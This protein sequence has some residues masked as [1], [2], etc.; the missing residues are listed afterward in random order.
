MT[1]KIYRI[2]KIVIALLLLVV[3]YL[4]AHNG[5]YTTIYEGHYVFDKWTKTILDL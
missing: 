5:R 1:D 3:L 2:A 4:Y